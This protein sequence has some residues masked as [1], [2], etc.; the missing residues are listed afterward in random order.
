MTIST[1]CPKPGSG[2]LTATQACVGTEVVKSA[3]AFGVN[4]AADEEIANI[5]IK[6]IVSFLFFP[7]KFIFFLSL[8]FYLGLGKF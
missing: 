6:A 7:S 4:I 3:F 8:N 2:E 5:R 1:D